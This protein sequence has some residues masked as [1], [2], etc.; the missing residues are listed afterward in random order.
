V[1]FLY[2]IIYGYYIIIVVQT[3]ATNIIF[4]MYNY[5]IRILVEIFSWFVRQTYKKGCIP[6]VKGAE[7]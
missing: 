1:F 2:C 7:L 4:K 3:S 6:K 5:I